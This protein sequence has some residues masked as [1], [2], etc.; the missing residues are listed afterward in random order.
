MKTSTHRVKHY[1]ALRSLDGR[2]SGDEATDPQLEETRCLAQAKRGDL[3]AFEN[4][5][6]CHE[7]RV[8]SFLVRW[9]GDR[10]TAEDVLQEATIKAFRKLDQLDANAAF[11]AWFFRIAINEAKVLVRKQARDGKRGEEWASAW[12]N[13]EDQEITARIGALDRLEIGLIALKPAD[14]L[15]LLLRFAEEMSFA[16]LSAVL[17]TAELVLKMRISRARKR[18]RR[19]ISEGEQECRP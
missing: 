16:E 13:S 12:N 9:L 19:A 14:R 6:R 15:L 3:R 1:E 17:G 2:R 10:S 7:S 8:F 4:L 5:V 18:F 11:R